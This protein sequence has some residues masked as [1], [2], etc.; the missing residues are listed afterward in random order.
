MKLEYTY[1]LETTEHVTYQRYSFHMRA[2]SSSKTLPFFASKGEC[3]ARL[4]NTNYEYRTNTTE[5]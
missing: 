5:L 1:E 2:S 3:L 4:A